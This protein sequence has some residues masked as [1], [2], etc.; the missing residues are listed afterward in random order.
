MCIYSYMHD[1]FFEF[2]FEMDDEKKMVTS[3]FVSVD[4]VN[5]IA[6]LLVKQ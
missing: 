1:F 3:F 2:S 6:A 5:L 4:N